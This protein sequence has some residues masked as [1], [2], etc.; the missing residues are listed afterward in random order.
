MEAEQAILALAAL[1]QS[2][3]L[4]VFRLLAKHEPEGLADGDIAKELAVPLVPAR[5][6][7]A[8]PLRYA[9]AP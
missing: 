4:D 2:T 3:R 9:S 1:A 8:A 5:S 6:A 7:A